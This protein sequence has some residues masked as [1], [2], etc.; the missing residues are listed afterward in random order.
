[1]RVSLLV[2][3]ASCLLWACPARATYVWLSTSE[4]VSPLGEVPEVVLAP[5]D[6]EQQIHVWAR[7]DPGKT[8]ASW[9]LNLK[10]T[11]NDVISFKSLVVHN[12][13]KGDLVGP[14]GSIRK[15]YHRVA[16]SFSST[17]PVFRETFQEDFIRDFM[18]FS[19]NYIFDSPESVD[20]VPELTGVYGDG[21]NSAIGEFDELY[22]PVNDAWL[23]A[24]VT[25]DVLGPGET[26]LFLQVGSNGIANLGERTGDHRVVLGNP[27]DPALRAGGGW[28]DALQRYISDWEVRGVDS[29][30]PD[31][32]IL[33]Q[34]DLRD[35]FAV[36]EPSTLCLGLMSLLGAVVLIARC[37]V[38][39]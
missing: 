21:L 36:P 19:V 6:A 37:R 17:S 33:V 5:G 3:V 15:R 16:D 9:S 34:G 12:P 13:T 18:G 4:S 11:N 30:T 23:L 10:S 31:A 29:A 32:T 1:M 20:G 8:L 22:D 39:A 35:G 26:A 24:S 2:A 27:D 7:P 25:Y 28:D 14:F 38:A